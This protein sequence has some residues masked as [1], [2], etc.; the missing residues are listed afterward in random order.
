[1]AAA[2]SSLA[3]TSSGQRAPRHL[4]STVRSPEHVRNVR[5]ALVLV[6]F[7]EAVGNRVYRGRFDSQRAIVAMSTLGMRK[8][9][10]RDKFL[11]LQGELD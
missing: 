8:P 11:S 5:Q 3:G 9:R 7:E 6:R 4:L 10:L 2:S 1:M